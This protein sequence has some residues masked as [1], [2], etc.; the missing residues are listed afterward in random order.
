M[1]HGGGGWKK[2]SPLTRFDVPSDYASL[3]GLTSG[4]GC[5]A[6]H[7]AVGIDAAIAEVEQD[8]LVTTREID[9][10]VGA[11]V[12]CAE[13]DKPFTVRVYAVEGRLLHEH[14]QPVLERPATRPFPTDLD[15]RPIGGRIITL[16]IVRRDGGTS[17]REPR[18]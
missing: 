18:S 11:I 6:L 10:P 7:G 12:V 16:R 14:H 5:T 1:G 2:E 8:G 4:G 13:S 15:G 3:G 17:K 9:A